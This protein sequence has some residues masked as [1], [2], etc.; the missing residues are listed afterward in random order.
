MEVHL[1][2]IGAVLSDV[3][4]RS[5][6]LCLL[7]I[8]PQQILIQVDGEA[9][10]LNVKDGQAS[11]SSP[12]QPVQPRA[13]RAGDKKDRSEPICLVECSRSALESARSSGASVPG[14]AVKPGPT[15]K[16]IQPA[17]ERLVR[18]FFEAPPFP[19]DDREDVIYP[20]LF[21]ANPTP[22]IFWES[23]KNVLRIL[24]YGPYLVTSG[25]SEPWFRKPELFA[26]ENVSG[27]GYEPVSYT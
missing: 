3:V 1:N 25:L 11:V 14:I 9:F 19:L 26:A 2:P 24:R 18:R 5:G 21:S 17:L 8:Q 6:Y 10:V 23:Q 7:G 22:T 12:A 27:A 4:H 20:A 15:G 16:L 13:Q